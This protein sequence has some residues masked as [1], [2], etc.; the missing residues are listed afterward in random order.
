MRRAAEVGVC[1]RRAAP[2]REAVREV[3]GADGEGAL[4][5]GD[6]RDTKKLC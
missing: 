5:E 3:E 2:A 6:L 1:A 4:A